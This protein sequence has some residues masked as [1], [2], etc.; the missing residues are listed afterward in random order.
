MHLASNFASHRQ[1]ASVIGIFLKGLNL[2]KMLIKVVND[3]AERG[4]KLMSDSSTFHLVP[5][6]RNHNLR[7]YLR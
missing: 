3:M 7:K 4:V 2:V 1:I 6:F 5:N